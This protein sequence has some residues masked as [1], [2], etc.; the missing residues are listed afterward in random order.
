[1]V[2]LDPASLVCARFTPPVSVA[3]A[4]SSGSE[5]V[6]P[7]SP[8]ACGPAGHLHSDKRLLR[9]ARWRSQSPQGRRE[10]SA[11]LLCVWA[12]GG[13]SLLALLYPAHSMAAK[14]L[15]GTCSN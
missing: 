11:C 12:G 15:G 10:A 14:R 9:R 13:G 2:N 5:A 6:F 3:W 1:M 8:G 4:V 7:S